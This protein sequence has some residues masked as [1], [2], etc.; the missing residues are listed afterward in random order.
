MVIERLDGTYN[1]RNEVGQYPLYNKVAGVVVTGNEDGAHACAE[2]TLF[3]MT[4][5]GC[6]VPPN[7]DTYWVGRRRARAVISRGRGTRAPLHAADQLL[8]RAQPA[9]HGPDH[10]GEPD[11]ADREHAGGDGRR[12]R[13]HRVATSS[14]RALLLNMLCGPQGPRPR[15]GGN[16]QRGEREDSEAGR[17]ADS[18]GARD[19]P[20]PALGAPPPRTPWP[21]T[22]ASTRSTS[23]APSPGRACGWS[24]RARRSPGSPSGSSAAS[25]SA[26]FAAG[27]GYRVRAA[28]GS[29]S[30]PRRG[31][32]RPLRSE[33]PL[34]LQPDPAR[35]WLWIPDDAGRNQ[36]C[37]RRETARARVRRA[38][39]RPLVEYS[40]YGYANPAGAESGISQILN[41]LGY[42]VVDVN[43]RGTGC[44][45]GAFDYFEKLQSL[46]GYDVVETVARQP[47]VLN[48]R[49]GMAGVSYG[50]ISQLFVGATRPPHLAA[51]TPLSVIDN[52]AT[53]L[54]PGGLLNTGFAL[55]WAQDRVDD[56]KP[57]S[58][59][60]G[61][62][63]AYKR[64]QEGDQIC[65]ANQTLHTAAADLIAK[66]HKNRVYRPKVELDVV[67]GGNYGVVYKIH[68]DKPR[69]M[70][71]MIMARGGVFKGPFKINGEIIPVPYSGVI[72]AFDGLEVL[73]RTTGTEDALDIE[74]TPPAGSAFPIDLI[75]YPL[76]DLK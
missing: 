27:K 18:G 34:D 64:I 4:H 41:L 62:G 5:L 11:P 17:R 67:N 29:L 57:A 2:T 1:E 68:A 26:G 50:G 72:T 21:S 8:V 12:R 3:N 6:V 42:A 71:V 23:P 14:R 15:R 39:I 36:P 45:G 47:W 59:T 31:D 70:A 75:F 55:Q 28:D 74:F 56:A 20:A 76:E 24:A 61:Q 65:K 35:R 43:M 51:I 13:A 53:T 63:W 48:G 44:S 40:G 52:T 30:A 25:S 7:A 58:P 73:A 32:E 38:P 9:P 10:A 49:V 19:R 46:D 16:E 60:D 54:Y 33:G 66:I 22:A 69:K 37:D